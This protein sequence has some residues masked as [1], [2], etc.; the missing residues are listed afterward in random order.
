M[1]VFAYS[2]PRF[3]SD[4]S[5]LVEQTKCTS[6]KTFQRHNHD[7]S[8]QSFLQ[9]FLN[10]FNKVHILYVK[11]DKIKSLLYMYFFTFFVNQAGYNCRWELK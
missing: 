3:V 6:S 1:C 4:I 11:Q 5:R 2:V 7:A 8:V 10:T 9:M